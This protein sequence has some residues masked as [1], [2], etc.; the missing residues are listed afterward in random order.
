MQKPPFWISALVLLGILLLG[1]FALRIN[2]NSESGDG[3]ESHTD[4]EMQN[5]DAA[6][7]NGEEVENLI[8]TPDLT[9]YSCKASYDDCE[10]V[11]LTDA[12]R[13]E[14]SQKDYAELRLGEYRRLVRLYESDESLYLQLSVDVAHGDRPVYR[15]VKQD[16]I[17]YRILS[18]EQSLVWQPLPHI[19]LWDDKEDLKAYD[20][21]NDTVRTIYD[22]PEGVSLHPP[23]ELGCQP[24]AYKDVAAGTLI[25]TIVRDAP[26]ESKQYSNWQVLKRLKVDAHTLSV[27]ELSDVHAFEGN[28]LVRIRD[29]LREVVVSN[30]NEKLAHVLSPVVQE[31][32][33]G[34]VEALHGTYGPGSDIHGSYWTEGEHWYLRYSPS[35]G[36][37]YA[38]KPGTDLTWDRLASI[39]EKALAFTLPY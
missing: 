23:C 17:F 9:Y 29:G 27:T 19:L 26:V 6:R 5:D 12:L 3:Y 7:L 25:L 24:V 36:T 20:F 15:L 2:A 4:S 38:W 21:S 16:G 14:H 13:S 32:H 18:G 39:P 35:S 37:F 22:S 10:P 33:Y 31:H 1:Y 30:L 11:T 8:L 28:S 34:V